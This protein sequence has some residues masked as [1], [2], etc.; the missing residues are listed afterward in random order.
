MKFK[1][2]RSR[3]LFLALALAAAIGAVFLVDRATPAETPIAVLYALPLFLAGT[4]LAGWLAV[5]I[6]ALAVAL[7][8]ADAVALF[9]TGNVYRWAGLA[10]LVIAVWWA[11]Q[12]GRDHARLRSL[13]TELALKASELERL[14]RD[15]EAMNSIVAHELRGALS[16]VAG[17][18]KLLLRK[19]DGE[20][21]AAL[22][23]IATGS[24]RLDRL[25]QDLL[26]E[27][28]IELGHLNLNRQACDAVQLVREQADFYQELTG[29]SVEVDVPAEPVF[30]NWDELRVTQV[31]RNLLSNA[32]KYSPPDEPVRAVV[33]PVGQDV[34]LS[35][36]NT[37][38]G[39][40]PEDLEDVFV[41]YRRLAAHRQ[42]EGSGLG[43]HV[44]RSLVERHGGRI[45]AS[46]TGETVEFQV[47]LPR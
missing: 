26:D 39:I 2:V 40:T 7:Y 47:T 4:L 27:A 16:S 31:I 28:N 18:S 23:A 30:G 37:A 45:Q 21:R 13:S 11:V 20:D 42:L 8:V 38:V 34:V 9:E 46:L 25:T 43:L 5:A 14:R 24:D 22:R 10:V 41:P 32:L 6:G 35:I 12:T 36:R 44:T 15:R 3:D 33:A 29:R 19:P 1:V 17:F